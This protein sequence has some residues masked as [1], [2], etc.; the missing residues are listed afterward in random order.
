LTDGTKVR[1]VGINCP[2][3]YHDQKLTQKCAIE[4]YDYLKSLISNKELTIKFNVNNKLDQFQRVLGDVYVGELW[5]NY[6]MIKNGFA[7]VYTTSDSEVSK[8]LYEAEE[9]AQ[10][11]KIGLWEGNNPPELFEKYQ[12]SYESGDLAQYV[13]KTVL[14][15]GV[16]DKL[17]K[18]GGA[19]ILS[20]KLKDGN[21]LKASISKKN[22]SHFPN[23]LK[24]EN[25]LHKKIS[26]MG[27]V[28]IYNEKTELVI[29]YPTQFLLK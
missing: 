5:V 1:L 26:I 4:A 10:A 15:T 3:N 25:F 18:N 16:V 23:T 8:K 11:N 29:R 13:N 12:P 9:Y 22:Y 19:T 2:E 14:I 24:S 28:N 6:E 27:R 21:I 17:Q 7:F 20:I